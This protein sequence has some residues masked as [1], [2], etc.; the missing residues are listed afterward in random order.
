VTL[1]F[2]VHEQIVSATKVL[3]IT[4]LEAFQLLRSENCVLFCSNR[5]MG[6]RCDGN[7]VNTCLKERSRMLLMLIDLGTFKGQ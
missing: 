4:F 2:A 6:F 5:R 3:R 7:H 1:I